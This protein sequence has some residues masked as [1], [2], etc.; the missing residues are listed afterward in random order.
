[1]SPS[2]CDVARPYLYSPNTQTD[3]GYF[4]FPTALFSFLVELTGQMFYKVLP[5]MLLLKD[6][7]GPLDKV[8]MNPIGNMQEVGP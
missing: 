2:M 3:L 8:L 7:E 6:T 4:T 1:M 5:R